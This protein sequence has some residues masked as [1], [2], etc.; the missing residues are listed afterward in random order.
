MK[1]QELNKAELQLVNGGSDG[2]ASS[3]T[4]IAL[5][6]GS[7]LSLS[8]SYNDGQGRS[9]ESKLEVLKDVRIGAGTN[10]NSQQG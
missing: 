2:A 1:A 10:A 5:G 9:Y 6:T 7:L 8:Y 3:S 4:G